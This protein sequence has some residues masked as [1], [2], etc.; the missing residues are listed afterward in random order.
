MFIN[1]HLFHPDA[2][3]RHNASAGNRSRHTSLLSAPPFSGSA[4]RPSALGSTPPGLPIANAPPCALQAGNLR[5][6]A[7]TPR[8]PRQSLI[9]IVVNR[10]GGQRSTRCL[11]CQRAREAC[12][13]RVCWCGWWRCE[14]KSHLSLRM[15]LFSGAVLRPRALHRKRGRVV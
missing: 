14:G 10:E 6:G 15:G 9:E 4:L 11:G 8:W 3:T 5:R 1:S 2:P 12:W 7:A 13:A